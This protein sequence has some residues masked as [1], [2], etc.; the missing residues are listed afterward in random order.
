MGERGKSKH[1]APECARL[2]ARIHFARMKF[3]RW[4]SLTALVDQV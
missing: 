1:C 3:R 4:N 2:R